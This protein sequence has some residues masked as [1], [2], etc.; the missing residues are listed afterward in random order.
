MY[1]YDFGHS[2]GYKKACFTKLKFV[3]IMLLVHMSM[4]KTSSLLEHSWRDLTL[5]LSMSS[6]FQQNCTFLKIDLYHKNDFVWYSELLI[7]HQLVTYFFVGPH[8]SI[9]SRIRNC[10]SDSPIEVIAFCIAYCKVSCLL[11]FFQLCVNVIC[12]LVNV[13]IYA[14]VW[15]HLPEI[16]IGWLP[17][18]IPCILWEC[19]SL[20]SSSHK[21]E[22]CIG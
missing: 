17:L 10:F 11:V 15:V 12:V 8:N 22:L 3:L 7:C 1:E 5:A 9:F 14:H 20:T 4:Y 6:D 19:L 13:D 16:N 2:K 21:L 18:I